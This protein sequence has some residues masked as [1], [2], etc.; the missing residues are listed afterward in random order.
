MWLDAGGGRRATRR[1]GPA[2]GGDGERSGP[3]RGAG[4]RRARE[5][6]VAARRLAEARAG[7]FVGLRPG[8][9]G[10]RRWRRLPGRRSTATAARI[11]PA[12]RGAL[13]LPCVRLG[14]EMSRRDRLGTRDLTSAQKRN[15]ER[16]QQTAPSWS[17]VAWRGLHAVGL[18][19]SCVSGAGPSG[20]RPI[21]P[22]VEIDRSAVKGVAGSGIRGA[23][24]G[25]LPLVSS[26]SLIFSN[27]IS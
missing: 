6:R 25:R 27:V 1:L 2:D 5:S 3:G 4:R 13:A 9:D 12:S 23:G 10:D 26:T 18:S 21:R 24:A 14:V 17:G 11:A 7:V 20:Y 19:P 8:R 16:E 15:G 22:M